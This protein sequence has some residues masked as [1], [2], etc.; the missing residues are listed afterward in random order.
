[1]PVIFFHR[2]QE[3][4]VYTVLTHIG[5]WVKTK[6]NILYPQC[7]FNI[8]YNYFYS[9]IEIKNLFIKKEKKVTFG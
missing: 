4:T 3:S 7:K 1:M 8:S 6:V 2:T 5:V 9:I